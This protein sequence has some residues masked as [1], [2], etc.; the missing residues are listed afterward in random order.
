MAQADLDESVKVICICP[1][2]VSTPLWTG[3]QGDNVRGQFS[4]TEDICITADDV[5]DAMKE[6]IEEPKYKGGALMEV[7]KGALRNELESAQSIVLE[8]E[9][10]SDEMV[11]F[12]ENLS[13]PLREVFAKERG[14]SVKNGTS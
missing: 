2:M 13:K 8:G 12:R 1:G 10:G 6:M 3:S 5:A 11:A 7:K 9:E 14:V 4:Y